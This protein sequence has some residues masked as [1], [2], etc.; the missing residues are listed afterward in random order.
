[1]LE[2]GA[3]ERPDLCSTAGAVQLS[4]AGALR[5]SSFAQPHSHSA[6]TVT[7]DNGRSPWPVIDQNGK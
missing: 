6:A 1:M 7:L 3:F 2:F 4:R 5:G